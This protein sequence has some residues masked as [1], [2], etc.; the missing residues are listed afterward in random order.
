VWQIEKIRQ[1]QLQKL[2]AQS[3]E[4]ASFRTQP[5]PS[6]TQKRRRQKK[7]SQ[8]PRRYLLQDRKLDTG[9]TRSN[10]GKHRAQ[11]HE[12]TKREQ[13]RSGGNKSRWD[14]PQRKASQQAASK[15]STRGKIEQDWTEITQSAHTELIMV[16]KTLESRFSLSIQENKAEQIIPRDNTYQLHQT[17]QPMK[18]NNNITGC[19]FLLDTL[20]I[21]YF[22]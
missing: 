2:R 15:T 18:R 3:R 16:A 21:F 17:C 19:I 12:A 5:K 7:L 13:F 10:S 1:R 20:G 9:K 4:A 14:F 22:G 11:E 8:T 6:S